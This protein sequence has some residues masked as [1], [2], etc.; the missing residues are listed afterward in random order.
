MVPLVGL[1]PTRLAALDFESSASTNST[2]GAPERTP[3]IARARGGSSSV[4]CGLGKKGHFGSKNHC[5]S[6]SMALH[7]EKCLRAAGG[8][9][10]TDVWLKTTIF[11]PRGK[12]LIYND[13]RAHKDQEY[14]NDD[15]K[16]TH[17]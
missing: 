12:T 14:A 16:G 8:G 17:T 11:G 13:T 9:A 3:I 6:D 10:I 15:G 4:G 5:K 2:T 7:H 1:E